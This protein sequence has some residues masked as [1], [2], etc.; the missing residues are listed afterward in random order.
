MGSFKNLSN[1]RSFLTK[2]ALSFASVALATFPATNSLGASSARKKYK[3][4]PTLKGEV[5]SD[6]LGT[7]LMHE[8]IL[9]F[10]GTMAENVGYEPIREDLLPE[11]IDFAVSVLNDAARVGIDTVVDLT[12]FRPMELYEQI[13]NR[14]PVNIIAS[15]GFYRQSKSPQWMADMDDERQMEELLLKDV[16]VGIDGTK[17]KAG[18][19][20]V[21]EDGRTLTDWEKK[22]FRSAARVNKATGTPIATHT[23]NAPE[24]FDLLVKTGANPRQILLSHVDVGRKGKPGE[25]LDIVKAGGYLEVDTFGQN[26]YTPWDELVAFLRSLCDAGYANRIIVSVDSNWHWEKGRK[27]F[28]GGGEPNFDPN[29]S[30]RTFAYMMTDVVPMLLKAGFSMKEVNTFLVD[31]PRNFF[32]NDSL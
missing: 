18:I 27:I 2:G 11:T 7:T 20:K 14:T 4:V 16:K 28:E 30:N 13:A 26:Y 10:A 9:W 6:K 25:L 15:T 12:P 21:A 29:A 19:I 17:L 8:H 5:A 3:M 1:R 22:A 31:N 32:S 23:G 24:Q